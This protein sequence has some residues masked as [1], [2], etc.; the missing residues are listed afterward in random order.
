MGLQSTYTGDQL[1]PRAH[2][3]LGFVFVS[4]GVAEVNQY[5]VTHVL[6]DETTKA[7]YC[8]RDALLVGRNDL[9][10]VFGVNARRQGR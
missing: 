3:S 9:A 5:A 2:G 7:T 8:L 1:Q 10:E 6:S 4:L